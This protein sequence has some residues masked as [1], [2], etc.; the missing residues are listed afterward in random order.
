MPEI[1]SGQVGPETKYDVAFSGGKL[2]V[3]VSYS[4]VQAGVSTTGYVDG[5]ALLEVLAN[6]VSNPLEKELIEGLKA[7]VATIP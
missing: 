5:G 7:I 3:S 6:A 2:S 1:A 4:G